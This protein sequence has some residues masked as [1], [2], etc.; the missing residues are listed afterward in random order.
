[1]SRD[2]GLSSLPLDLP[3]PEDDGAAR[4]LPG[5]RMPDLALPSTSGGEVLLSGLERR[6]VV[7]VYPMTAR[8]GVATPDGWDLIPGARGCTPEAC[9]FRDHHGDLRAT[10]TDVYGLSSQSTEYQRE[11]V[12]RLALPFPLLSDERMA[13]VDT[14]RLPTFD[15]EGQRFFKR[16]TLVVEA[17]VIHHVFYPVFPPDQHAAQ[18]SEWLRR[19]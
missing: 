5:M 4:H 18:V 9:G 17:G 1:M 6:T 19:A 12:S 8:P 15:V 14:L 13:M 7:Y 3:A 11:A 2:D 10:G 16:L